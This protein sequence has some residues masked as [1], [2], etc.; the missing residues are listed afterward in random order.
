MK[1]PREELVFHFP[2]YQSDDGPQSAILLGSLKL[3]NFYEDDRDKLFDLSSDIG[4][5]NDL[6]ATM[7]AETTQLRKKLDTYLKAVGAQF[8][9]PNPQY[10]P[11]RPA[12]SNKKG[13][14]KGS[15]KLS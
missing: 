7:P 6:S 12:T 1:R 11:T 15:K 14:K 10:D 13:G 4:E 9:T 3:M 8:P 2:H 5:R